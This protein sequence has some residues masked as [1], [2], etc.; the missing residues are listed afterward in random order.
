MLTGLERPG[1]IRRGP[2]ERAAGSLAPSAGPGRPRN[3]P[4]LPRYGAVV[5]DMRGAD[6]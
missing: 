2:L 5:S 1:V 6:V 3:G 4:A